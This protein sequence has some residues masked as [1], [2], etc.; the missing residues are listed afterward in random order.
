MGVSLVS[1]SLSLTHTLFFL[2]LS[3]FLLPWSCTHGTQETQLMHIEDLRG[4]GKDVWI[5]TT[6]KWGLLSGGPTTV[7]LADERFGPM[8]Q[9]SFESLGHTHWIGAGIASQA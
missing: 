6:K 9:G 3:L 2:S 1:L 5:W 7:F 4:G 8:G